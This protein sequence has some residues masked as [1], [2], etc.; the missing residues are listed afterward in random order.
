MKPT[1]TFIPSKGDILKASS[2]QI[3]ALLCILFRI[4]R[5]YER[6]AQL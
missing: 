2:I 4:F 3:A 5:E 6:G 1:I